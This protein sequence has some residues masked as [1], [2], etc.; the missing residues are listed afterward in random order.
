MRRGGTVP[1]I[2]MQRF[3][4]YELKDHNVIEPDGHYAQD[5]KKRFFMAV[6]RCYF[7]GQ[8]RRAGENPWLEYEQ[9]KRQLDA[10]CEGNSQRYEDGLRFITALLGL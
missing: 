10:V 6:E 1:F 8:N 5:F 7:G 3:T 2:S 9:L 4:R